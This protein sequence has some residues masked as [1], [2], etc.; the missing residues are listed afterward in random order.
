MK[1][2]IIPALIAATA[3]ARAG[4]A[5]LPNIE[6]VMLGTV[7]AGTKYGWKYGA[8]TWLFSMLVSD[9]I[10]YG[11]IPIFLLFGTGI[12]LVSVSTNLAYGFVGSLSGFVKARTRKDF[13][14]LAAGLTLLYDFL[15][16]VA[17]GLITGIP[18]PAALVA[19][20]PFSIV[21]VLSNAI[22]VGIVAP[23]AIAALAAAETGIFA[24]KPSPA[25]QKEYMRG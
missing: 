22:I 3:V 18:I 25:E 1:K 7:V 5:G 13:A 19:G 23:W 9:F 6:P 11:T 4:M 12:F 10:I 20:I 21:H 17:W 2:A 24:S 15:T 16:N 14:L 8:L